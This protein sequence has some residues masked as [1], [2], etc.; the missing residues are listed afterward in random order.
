MEKDLG[1]LGKLKIEFKSGKARKKEAAPQIPD[2]YSSFSVKL[3]LQDHKLDF[4]IT[5]EDTEVE[6]RSIES[7]FSLGG[8]GKKGLMNFKNRVLRGFVDTMAEVETI[9]HNEWPDK[10]KF[11][12][13][14]QEK[15]KKCLTEEELKD[16][17]H[18]RAFD[19]SQN[20]FGQLKEAVYERKYRFGCTDEEA[21]ADRKLRLSKKRPSKEVEIMYTLME[22]M[23]IVN[24][25]KEKLG[26]A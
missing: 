2:R 6:V 13:T 4:L 3:P 9:D 20:H 8:Y 26:L 24:A 19:E 10:E 7:Q 25:Q 17:F 23:D 21:V 15:I 11:E 22:R 16:K 12:K 5:N 14:Y 1:K 18:E